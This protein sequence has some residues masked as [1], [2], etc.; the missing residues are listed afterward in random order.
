MFEQVCGFSS[1]LLSAGREEKGSSEEARNALG[2]VARQL[3]PLEHLREDPRGPEGGVG[4]RHEARD[5]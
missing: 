4:W 1:L 5:A 2:Q 3:L